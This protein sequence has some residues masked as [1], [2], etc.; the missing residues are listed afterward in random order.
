MASLSLCFSAHLVHLYTLKHAARSETLFYSFS[1]SNIP[2][3]PLLPTSPFSALRNEI[4]KSFFFH[5]QSG[6]HN[7]TNQQ[8][9]FSLC[10]SLGMSSL[11]LPFSFSKFP[12]SAEEQTPQTLPQSSIFLVCHPQTH[13]CIHYL[14]LLVIFFASHCGTNCG[15]KAGQTFTFH[16]TKWRTE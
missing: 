2:S 5:R 13:A 10:V 6:Q 14:K 9:R 3:F 7:Y 11:S 16:L 4:K 1:P 12:N 8:T 15:D